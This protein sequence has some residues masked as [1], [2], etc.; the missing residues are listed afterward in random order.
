[1]NMTSLWKR[2]QYDQSVEEEWVYL[3][4]LLVKEEFVAQV[5]QYFVDQGADLLE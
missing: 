2:N 3:R 4:H 1:M 5:S